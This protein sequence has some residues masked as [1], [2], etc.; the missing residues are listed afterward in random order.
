VLDLRPREQV[1]TSALTIFGVVSFSTH[2]PKPVIT[3]PNVCTS[4]LGT[5]YSYNILYTN[6]AA[7]ANAATGASGNRSTEIEGGGLPPSPVGGS[8][9]LDSGETVP[10]CIGCSDAPLDA[11]DPPAPSWANQPKSRVYWQI[12]Q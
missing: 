10:F 9:T 11:T 2:L 12:E 6:A 7:G 5:S 4:D 1:V 8:V 3:D